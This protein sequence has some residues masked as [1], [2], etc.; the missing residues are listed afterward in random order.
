MPDRLEY[1][2]AIAS[3]APLD[4]A[5]AWVHRVGDDARQ[6]VRYYVYGDMAEALWQACKELGTSQC[7]LLGNFGVDEEGGF[8]EISGFE[9]LQRVDSP[10][11]ERA[12]SDCDSWIFKS[13]D[14]RPLLG[15][16]FSSPGSHARMTEPMV[17]IH[18][19][20]LNVPFQ[21][22][23]VLDPETS[24]FGLFARPPHGRFENVAFRWVQAR[25]TTGERD[26]DNSVSETKH[27]EGE[28]N[29]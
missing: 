24:E 6:P 12:R 22:L 19:S 11:L 9:S 18:Y 20:L 27:T 23:A 8:V 1:S 10:N 14:G 16:L 5:S 26:S 17:R 7:I 25:P 3:K 13:H 28:E 4:T 2:D 21:V 15:V 29:V